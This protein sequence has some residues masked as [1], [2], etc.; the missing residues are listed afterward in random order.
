MEEIL[1]FVKKLHSY[2]GKVLYINLLGM[3]LMSLLEGVGIL[4]LIPMINITGIVN[5]DIKGN[6]L[7]RVIELIKQI[8]T[9]YALPIILAVYVFLVIGQSLL[10]RQITL[11]NT[12]IQHGFFRHLRMETYDALLHAD[13]RFFIKHRKSD[14]LNILTAQIATASAGANS[15]LQF[16]SSII[17][18]LIQISIA[19]WLSPIITLFVLICGCVLLFFSRNFLQR[20]LSLGNRNYESGKEYLAGVTDQINGIKDIKSNTLEKSRLAWF[21]SVTLKMHEEQL[22]YMRL[23][24]KSQ[25]YYKASSAI[26]MAVFIYFAVNMFSAQSGQLLLV[27]AIFSRLWPRV[28]GI[29][30]SL[31]QIASRIPSYKAVIEM[32]A[33]CKAAKEFS[34]VVVKDLKPLKIEQG[35]EC[36]NVSFRYNQNESVYALKDINLFIP[37][38]RMTA[39]VGR[40]GAG[41]STLIDL[42]MGLNKPEH[43]ELLIDGTSLTSDNLLPLRHTISYVAQDPYLFNASIRENLLLV[44]SKATEEELWE[45]L[46]FSSAADFVRKLPNGLDTLIGDRGIRLSGGERQRLVLARAILRKPSILV[47]DEATSAL[48]TENEAKIQEALEKLNGRITIVVIAHRLSTIRNADQVIVIEQGKVIQNG[49]FT[50]LANEKTSVFGRLL[51]NQREAMV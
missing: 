4:F 39:V 5:L 50:Q 38:N 27:V 45:A 31:E 3:T 49:D 21:A 13:W 33:E 32:Q 20:S 46:E 29:Q 24:T 18:T 2:A 1:F 30:A 12:T 17:Y 44:E 19:F 35:L 48:D 8:P 9:A 28:A 42:L 11:R 26:L 10:Q 25:L 15:F 22:D 7:T 14:L 34:Q 40:S 47:L 36:R 43:G 16:V 41:K 37:A 6:L 23:N 51:K